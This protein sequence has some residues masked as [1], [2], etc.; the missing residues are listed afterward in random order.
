MNRVKIKF[1]GMTRVDDALDA[2]ALGVDA[3][4]LIFTGRSPRRVGIEQAIAIA[5]AVPPFVA[6]VGLFLDQEVETVARIVN[7]VPL[8][9]LQFHGRE[10]A[11]FCRMFGKPYLKVVPMMD[12]VD[13]PAFAA[14]Y[15]DAQG[16]VL[17]SHRAGAAG[18]TGIPF[19]W[20]RARAEL[21][22]AIVLAGG[23]TP[24]NVRDAVETV[25]PYAV[26]VS[27]G[28]ERAIGDKDHA[29]MQAFVAAVRM[30]GG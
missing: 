16:F 26:D 30:A 22:R 24:E 4:G 21:D 29:K 15:P 23:L 18:G 11:A 10:E 13:V 28:I 6:R 5:R 20:S 2:A 9:V 1:C 14:S 25:R 17:D 27:S 8:D 19:D 3:I 12:V 7:A